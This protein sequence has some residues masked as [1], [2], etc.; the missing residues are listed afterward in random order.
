MQLEAEK[1]PRHC[2]GDTESESQADLRVEQG[3]L[4]AGGLR[5]GGSLGEPGRKRRVSCDSSR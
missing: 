1:E 2:E 5:G 3:K 4:R